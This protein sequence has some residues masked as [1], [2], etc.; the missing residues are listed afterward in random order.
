MR[1][2]QRVNL[3]FR[4]G[5]ATQSL[6]FLEVPIMKIIFI[7]HAQTQGNLEKRY[8]GRTNEPLCAGG[9]NQAAALFESGKLP[10][11]DKLIASPY[12]RCTQTAE[13]LYPGMAYE[14]YNDLRECDFGIF[15][16]KTHDELLDSKEYTAWLETDCLRDI[17]GGESVTAFKRRC[18]AAFLESV[19]NMPNG[20]TV[21]F[22]IHGGCIM[23]ILEHFSRPQK[24]FQEYYV[25][26][27]EV[28]TCLYDGARFSGNAE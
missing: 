6:G 15:E 23:A 3:E 16:G 25:N 7:R 1:F 27:C 4:R 5:R 21:V 14:I 18:R 28:V 24:E 20:A 17:P 8:I 13:I 26:N 9:V 19:R 12:L 11:P 10:R 22:V 2:L